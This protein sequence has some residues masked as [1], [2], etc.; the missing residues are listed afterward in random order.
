MANQS[1]YTVPDWASANI[2]ANANNY[3][4][5][6]NR[7]LEAGFQRGHA[8]FYDD[9]DMQS[10]RAKRMDL[11]K[12]YSGSELGAM[13]AQAESEISGQRSNYLKQLASKAGRAG[14]GGARGVAMQAAADKGFQGNRAELERKMTLDNANL[15]RQGT[16]DLQDFL[17][18]QRF[19]EL[20]TGLGYAELGANDR[21]SAAQAQIANKPP[22]RQ[23]FL[24]IF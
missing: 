22:E 16:N 18:R 14:I 12:G 3:A 8:M 24:G 10:L 1:T 9:P 20:G 21:A 19:G 2:R 7:D 15:T 17:M 5:E 4:M 13:K 11:S 6:R 23:K